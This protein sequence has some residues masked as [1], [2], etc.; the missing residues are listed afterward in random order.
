MGFASVLLF[1]MYTYGL[2]FSLSRFVRNSDN[3]LERNIMRFGFGLAGLVVLG[4]ILNFLKLPVD[5]GIFLFISLVPALFIAGL[6]YLSSK[7]RVGFEFRVRKSDIWALLALGVFVFALVMYS[8]GALKYP[9]LED[10]D[11]W[12]HA[13]GAKYVAVEKKAYDTAVY[14]FAYMDPYPPGYDILMGVLHQTEPS[15]QFV[16]KFFNGLI[17]ALGIL[18]FYFVAKHLAGPGKAA[19]SAFVL[20]MIPSYFTHFIWAHSLVIA[21]FFPAMYAFWMIKEDR[22]W[23]VPSAFCVAAI[24][25]S[26][27][28]QPIKLAVMI[29]VF[30][31]VR[32]WH[33]RRFPVCEISAGM[34]GVAISLLWWAS[35]AVAMFGYANTIAGGSAFGAAGGSASRPYSFADFVF[36]NAIPG[37][38]LINVPPGFGPVVSIL[39]VL[40]L[41]AVALSYKRILRNEKPWLAL[42]FIW[43]LFAFIFTNSA[44]LGLPF[45]LNPFRFWLLLAI[46]VAV[47]AAEGAWFAASFIRLPEPVKM[48]IVIVLAVLVFS[49]SG[50]YK[51]GINNSTGWYGGPLAVEGSLPGYL[52]LK[53]L[54]PNARVLSFGDASFIIGLDAYSCAWC[55]EDVSFRKGAYSRSP[56]EIHSFMKRQGYEFLLLSSIELGDNSDGSQYR[57]YNQTVL[58]KEIELG[59]SSLFSTANIYENGAVAVFRAN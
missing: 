24:L 25:L 52:W 40:G 37:N 49:T 7:P 13:V 41:V 20:A 34:L 18:W 16:L 17:I 38:S 23:I 50:L 21:L 45:G 39:L 26:Q 29:F 27:P 36:P 33:D 1:F 55:P 43:F 11:P 22:R 12:G 14:N 58:K 10:E 3:F 51:W 48:G 46:P 30:I 6:D 9:Y 44:T 54:P 59:N 57:F 19:F 31:A 53:T 15:L 5:W 35:R 8:G 4:V 42:V 28:D 56:D 47:L 2:G 32:A